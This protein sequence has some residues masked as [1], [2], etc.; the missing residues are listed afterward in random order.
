MS[1]DKSYYGHLVEVERQKQ[2]QQLE[3][4]ERTAKFEARIDTLE[5][6][7]KQLEE[8]VAKLISPNVTVM[9]RDS[10]ADAV[11]AVLP[12]GC[13]MFF[14]P[15]GAPGHRLQLTNSADTIKLIKQFAPSTWNTLDGDFAPVHIGKKIMPLQQAR[16]QPQMHHAC[17]AGFFLRSTWDRSDLSKNWH[18]FTVLSWWDS[19]QG[20]PRPG[21]V[22]ALVMEGEQPVEVM[23]TA[24]A[25]DFPQQ[26]KNIGEKL[27]P[28]LD[29]CAAGVHDFGSIESRKCQRCSYDTNARW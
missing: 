17:G 18:R 21:S 23:L 2:K 6:R 13:S 20:D 5:A 1:D 25:R 14:G 27:R 16:P 11:A 9:Q 24:F 15:S 19:T 7:T 10:I 26:R 28:V 3:D 12:V 22:A 8:V 4:A 29:T